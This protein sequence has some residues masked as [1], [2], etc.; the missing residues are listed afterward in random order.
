MLGTPGLNQ[1]L[2]SLVHRS[3]TISDIFLKL[4]KVH[5]LKLIDAI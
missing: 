5:Y 3:P 2:S 1:E 4:R